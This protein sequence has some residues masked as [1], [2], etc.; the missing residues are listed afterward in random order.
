V[1][2]R[3]PTDLLDPRV[4]HPPVETLQ[5]LGYEGNTTNGPFPS[6]FNRWY[7][8]LGYGSK[9]SV[10]NTFRRPLNGATK[11]AG[12]NPKVFSKLPKVEESAPQLSQH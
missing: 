10:N 6:N 5:D 12:P 1:N 11:Q 7:Y 3:L 2:R 8:A 9:F 4:L